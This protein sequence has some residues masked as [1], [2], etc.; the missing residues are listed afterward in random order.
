MQGSKAKRTR[1][2]EASRE[3]DDSR[4]T[5]GWAGGGGVIGKR[6]GG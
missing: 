4:D 5:K 3:T 6:G 2:S 1:A